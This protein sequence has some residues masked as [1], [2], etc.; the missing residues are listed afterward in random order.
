MNTA[1]TPPTP[2]G[3]TPPGNEPPGGIEPPPQPPAAPPE[4]AAPPPQDPPAAPQLNGPVTVPAARGFSWLL[5]AW[6]YFTARPVDWIL[7]VL[8]LFAI[9]VVLGMIPL[10]G[11]L[12]Q[13]LISPIFTGGLMLGCRAIDE[14]GEFRFNYLFAGFQHHAANLATVGGLYFAAMLAVMLV[15][16]MLAMVFGLG[17]GGLAG[18]AAMGDPDVG[19]VMATGAAGAGM[20]LFV[21]LMLALMIPVV[22]AYYFAPVLVMLHDM[23]PLEAMKLSFQ[24]CLKNLLPFLLYGLLVMVAAIIAGIPMM[25]GFLV[26]L[27]MIIA[28]MY[29]AYRDIYLAV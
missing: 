3:D 7:V 22:M 24:G 6:S 2:P 25:L 18:L 4:P 20:L 21:L 26:L 8:A 1:G 19:G 28:S 27:P 16:G 13:M 12:A 9:N 23:P 29:L 11:P 14:G 17:A 5:D 15:A 10:L